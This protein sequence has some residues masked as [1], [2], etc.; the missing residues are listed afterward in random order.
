MTGIIHNN[1]SL[2]LAVPPPF[3]DFY[4]KPLLRE[5]IGVQMLQRPKVMDTLKP[6]HA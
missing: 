4:Y 1:N 2:I 5:V 6:L 3:H